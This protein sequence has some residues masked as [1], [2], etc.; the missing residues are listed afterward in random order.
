MITHYLKMMTLTSLSHS[1]R[2]LCLV[3]LSFSLAILASL[4]ALSKKNIF[5]LKLHMKL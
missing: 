5:S 4:S 1:R 3:S 2:S